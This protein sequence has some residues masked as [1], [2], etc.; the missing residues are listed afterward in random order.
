MDDDFSDI[1]ED[2]P[3][4]KK[5]HDYDHRFQD[6]EEYALFSS[7]RYIRKHKLVDL[8]P[9]IALRSFADFRLIVSTLFH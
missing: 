7:F 4:M 3:A 2:A 5:E 9:K 1:E 6:T 8:D